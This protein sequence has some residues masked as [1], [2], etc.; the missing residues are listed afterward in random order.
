APALEGV[1]AVIVSLGGAQLKDTSTR[2]VGTQRL[3]EA[4]RQREVPRII[5]VS[6][7]GVGDSIHQLD[8]QGQYVVET[9]I[10]EAVEDHGRQEALVQESG[11]QWTVVRPGGLTTDPLVEYTADHSGEIRI[12]SIPRACVANFPTDRKSTRL[13]SS[14]VS[15]SYA[16]FCLKKKKETTPSR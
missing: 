7:A 4:M 14:H 16:V 8:A 10:K 13:N 11:L 3:V 15:I 2:S 5:I 12:S 1:D 6:S 9:I